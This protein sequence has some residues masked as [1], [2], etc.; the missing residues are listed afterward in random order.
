MEKDKRKFILDERMQPDFITEQE[1]D[2][3]LKEYEESGK[4]ELG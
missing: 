4:S 3:L 2:M 1:C